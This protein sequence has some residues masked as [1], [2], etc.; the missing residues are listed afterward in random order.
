M[1]ARDKQTLIAR[2]D[3]KSIIKTFKSE[4]QIIH[5]KD[6]FEKHPDV[7]KMFV[8]SHTSR[9]TFIRMTYERGDN[10]MIFPGDMD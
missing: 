2:G 6:A 7:R 10:Q 8:F 9:F 5:D 3:L 1:C 4:D